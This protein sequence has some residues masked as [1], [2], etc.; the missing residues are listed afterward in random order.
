[1]PSGLYFSS[2]L[3]PGLLDNGS[4]FLIREHS[5]MKVVVL[6]PFHRFQLV[7]LCCA[8][9]HVSRAP[10]STSAARLGCTLDRR[11][12]EDDLASKRST[13][14]TTCVWKCV[15]RSCTSAARL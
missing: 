13:V 6:P 5:L 7:S 14:I 11:E 8:D 10:L 12:W 3:R 4:V 15:D 2:G 9:T 1:M